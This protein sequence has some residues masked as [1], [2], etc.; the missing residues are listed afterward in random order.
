MI[1]HNANSE[2][3]HGAIARGA[4]LSLLEGGTELFLQSDQGATEKELNS[5]HAR[6]IGPIRARRRGQRVRLGHRTPPSV[7]R[8][9]SYVAS[10]PPFPFVPREAG[11][12]V[13]PGTFPFCRTYSKASRRV[14][15]AKTA[16]RAIRTT[17]NPLSV[18]V[19]A[20]KA[21]V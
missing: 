19:S 14:N 7:R 13:G 15:R 1:G 11:A 16:V 5:P 6:P 18:F 20:I 4:R 10:R 9:L 8:T 17:V 3:S 2:T 12:D 21:Y